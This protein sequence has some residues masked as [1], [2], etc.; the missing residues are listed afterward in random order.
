MAISSPISKLKVT[1]GFTLVEICIAVALISILMAIAFAS[2]NNSKAETETKKR[3]ATIASIEAAKTRYILENPN[4]IAGIEAQLE[5]IAP[6][7]KAGGKPPSS[8]LDLVR[9][10]GRSTNDLDLGSYQGEVATF[11]SNQSLS[12]NVPST[13][14][15]TTTP[16]FTNITANN[17]TWSWGADTNATGYQYQF[18]S[19]TNWGATPT[20]YNYYLPPG[21]LSFAGLTPS[22]T[23]FVRVRWT[24]GTNMGNW[25]TNTFTTLP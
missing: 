12:T 1:K 21:G 6:Y 20:S 7:M 19:G 9:G 22:T 3:E 23:Y 10:T 15:I 4:N 17:A 11:T 14:T 2:L 5:H 8:L 13:P 24:N 18:G 16:T 25:A